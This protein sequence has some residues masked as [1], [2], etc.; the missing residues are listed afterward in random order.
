[1]GVRNRGI[2]VVKPSKL[3][4]LQNTQTV[5]YQALQHTDLIAHSN[6]FQITYTGKIINN[7]RVC[8]TFIFTN[9]TVHI[10]EKS[11]TNDVRL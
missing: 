11:T 10:R 3:M 4:K 1:M 7:K 6:D 2:G 8:I 5:W 9:Y